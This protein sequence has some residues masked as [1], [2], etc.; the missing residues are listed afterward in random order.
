MSN[1]NDAAVMVHSG[2]NIYFLYLRQKSV[3]SVQISIETN[4][5]I[6]LCISVLSDNLFLFV[7]FLK[8]YVFR[9]PFIFCTLQKFKYLV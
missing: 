1:T 4:Y 7:A 8:F 5:Q 3:F 9:N 6:A 2:K